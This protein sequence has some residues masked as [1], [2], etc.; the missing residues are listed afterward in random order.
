MITAITTLIHDIH[1]REAH[2]FFAEHRDEL[3]VRQALRS[4]FR[5]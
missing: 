2:L 4:A 3:D 5:T 1:D